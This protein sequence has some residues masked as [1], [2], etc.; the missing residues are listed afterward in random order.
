M[1]ALKMSHLRYFLILF[2]FLAALPFRASAQD[3]TIVGTVTDPSGSVVANVKVTLTNVETALARTITTNE[4][5]QY[6]A[7]ELHIGH[8]NV[9]AEATGFKVAE[10]KGLV[11]NVGD[12][13]RVDFQMVLGGAS[14]TVTVEA[15]AIAVQAD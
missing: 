12:R 6:A 5:G 2:V 9:K 1:P 10:Q 7:V 13:T 15:N 4:S 8:Y 3:A 14:E 11:L